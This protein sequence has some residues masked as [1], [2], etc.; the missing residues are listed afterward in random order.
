MREALL[1]GMAAII[2]RSCRLGPQGDLCLM[3][4][5]CSEHKLADKLLKYIER[6][7][8][9]SAEI[10]LLREEAAINRRQYAPSSFP[11]EASSPD[12]WGVCE[13]AQ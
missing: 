4:D 8:L 11:D 5:E 3:H 10:S 2:R 13:E 7:G 1:E 6:R 12:P 9:P